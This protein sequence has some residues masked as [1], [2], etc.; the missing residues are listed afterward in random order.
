M[1]GIKSGVDAAHRAG[2]QN[3]GGHLR[4]L[5][6]EQRAGF[7]GAARSATGEN[8]ANLARIARKPIL[9]ALAK[10]GAESVA[11][12]GEFPPELRIIHKPS[13]GGCGGSIIPP[14]G[15]GNRRMAEGGL[16]KARP[17][18]DFCP[19]PPWPGSGRGSCV[20]CPET[21]PSAGALRRWYAAWRFPA[22]CPPASAA[23]PCCPAGCGGLRSIPSP[24]D[25]RARTASRLARCR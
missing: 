1:R 13:L 2:R 21:A 25:K 9:S 14:C 12:P 19:W 4:V 11:L 18:R 3:V 5:E 16:P 8:H 17:R 7:V 20:D 10:A 24:R 22:T 15:A 6:G 23:A